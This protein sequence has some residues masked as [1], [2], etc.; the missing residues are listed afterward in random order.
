[1]TYYDLIIKNGPSYLATIL[2][3]S[4]LK[5][6]AVIVT[7]VCKRFGVENAMDISDFGDDARNKMIQEHYDFLMSEVKDEQ[8]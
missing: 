3:E 6:M 7:K 5:A 1:M 8:S 2:T 4:K